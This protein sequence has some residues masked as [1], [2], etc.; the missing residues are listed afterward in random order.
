MGLAKTYAAVNEEGIVSARRRLRDSETGCVRDFVIRAD[1]ER[2]ECVSRIESRNSCGWT[3]FHLR[4]EQ[5]FLTVA[6][7]SADVCVPAVDGPQNFTK[8]EPPNVTAIAFCN[9]G[10]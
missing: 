9:A 7:S 10:M 4:G 3:R 5:R 8:R 2:F 1:D 6:E